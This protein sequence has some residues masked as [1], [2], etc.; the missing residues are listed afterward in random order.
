VITLIFFVVYNYLQITAAQAA[1]RAKAW[2][3]GRSLDGHP[4]DSPR[5]PPP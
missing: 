2:E 1:A 4:P 3:E 5:S